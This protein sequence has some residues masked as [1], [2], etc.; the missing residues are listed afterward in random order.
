MGLDNHSG[1]Y[2]DVSGK[3]N[4]AVPLLGEVSFCFVLVWFD[5]E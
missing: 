1:C 4:M 5:H 3:G 2:L